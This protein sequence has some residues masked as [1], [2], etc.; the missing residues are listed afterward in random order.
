MIIRETERERGRNRTQK[1]GRWSRS[2]VVHELYPQ[3]SL[4]PPSRRCI[5]KHRKGQDV[6]SKVLTRVWGD[7]S[8]RTWPA[9]AG[10]Q[11]QHPSNQSGRKTYTRGRQAILLFTSARR[12][13]VTVWASSEIG[14][15]RT[16]EEKAADDALP[17]CSGWFVPEPFMR[18]S[19]RRGR[20]RAMRE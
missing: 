1:D 5:L 10:E 19:D 17:N 18:K 11:Q 13:W 4:N 3:D 20:G 9:R 12:P 7:W 15:W 16:R 14:R 8:A 2:T 6:D